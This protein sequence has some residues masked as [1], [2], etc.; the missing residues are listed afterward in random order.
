M[1]SPR[2]SL[3]AALGCFFAALACVPARAGGST[4][5]VYPGGGKPLGTAIRYA[6]PGD[7]IVVHDGHYW[8]NA[9]W[10]PA[11][12]PRAT[13]TQPIQL[14]AAQ[15]A[16]P[17]L[18]GVLKLDKPSYWI[19]DGIN[20]TRDPKRPID[21][22]LL[23]LVGGT[24][25]VF[26][27]GE[28][29]GGEGVANV[30]ITASPDGSPATNWRFVG[31]CVH[32][33]GDGPNSMNY[34]NMYVY[35]G[36]GSGSSVIAGNVFFNAPN[37]NHIK[38]AA[39]PR[40]PIAADVAIRYNTMYRAPQGVLVSYGSRSISLSRNLIVGRWGGR[41]DNPAIRGHELLNSTNAAKGNASWGYESVLKN[42][43]AS[44]GKIR[45]LG[46]NVK[47]QPRFNSVG[48]C[49]GFTPQT[50]EAKAYGHLAA[51]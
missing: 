43:Q 37:G 46:G 22:A 44:N 41:A 4:I 8:E 45:N 33:V 18:H 16:R 31:N 36:D 2:L 47:L 34:H 50:A 14:I 1:R 20:I 35:A 7:T 27:N 13:A 25:W 24:G 49:H 40:Q 21:S 3:V 28:I 26:R 38:A 11:D 9:G 48:S 39:P 29:W 42:T 51:R 30:S 5:H 10:R 12:A 32:D 6:E 15:G 17:V 23:K 19:I